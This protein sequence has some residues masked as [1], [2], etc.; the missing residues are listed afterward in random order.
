[1]TKNP[2]ALCAALRDLEMDGEGIDLWLYAKVTEGKIVEAPV[3][4]VEELGMGGEVR[5]TKTVPIKFL[6]LPRPWSEGW[7][8]D[9]PLPAR[10]E[11]A[12]LQPNMRYRVRVEGVIGPKK[13]K[14]LSE[15]ILFT[16]NTPPG[17]ANGRPRR[18][19]GER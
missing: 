2:Q 9:P 3:F 15:A 7:N 14:W 11:F 5:S 12:G 17:D 8:G 4:V 1:L 10:F 19:R 18:I 16:T 6:L 13:E